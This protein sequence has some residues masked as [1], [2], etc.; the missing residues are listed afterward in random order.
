M[1]LY[2]DFDEDEDAQ[3]SA[4]VHTV[5]EAVLTKLGIS[6]TSDYPEVSVLLTDDETIQAINSE[7]RGIE[8]PTDVLSFPMFERADLPD[9]FKEGISL[10]DIVISM[11][12]MRAQ[13]KEYGH[14]EERELAFLV[15]HGMLHLL[16]HDHEEESER[17]EME[18]LQDEI[19]DELGIRRI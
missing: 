14:S 9:T 17:L 10:G 7:Y 5:A 8:R 19:L 1:L 16:G 2:F 11:E 6:H 12:R 13:A 15:T 4:S 18:R 3:K